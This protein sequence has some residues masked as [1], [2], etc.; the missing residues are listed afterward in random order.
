MP[1]PNLKFGTVNEDEVLTTMLLGLVLDLDD[2][3]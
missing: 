1:R 2:L 3:G